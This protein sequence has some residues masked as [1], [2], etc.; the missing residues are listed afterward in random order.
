[1]KRDG[2]ELRLAA[3]DLAVFAACPHATALDLGDDAVPVELAD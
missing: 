2:D 3:T 1:M